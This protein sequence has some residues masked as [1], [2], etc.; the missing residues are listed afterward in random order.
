MGDNWSKLRWCRLIK[1]R[2]MHPLVNK[3]GCM[4]GSIDQTYDAFSF[5]PSASACFLAFNRR[6]AMLEFL[7]WAAANAANPKGYCGKENRPAVTFPPFIAA[8]YW[9]K[10]REMKWP[11]IK[12]RFTKR[13]NWNLPDAPQIIMLDRM[14][15]RLQ[16]QRLLQQHQTKNCA[17]LKALPNH[18]VMV[19]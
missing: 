9:A 15:K 7:L 6:S 16:Q 10:K 8:A 4:D 1:H 11:K 3:L 13:L 5:S 12:S 14:L 17:V 18:E 2:A 19:N